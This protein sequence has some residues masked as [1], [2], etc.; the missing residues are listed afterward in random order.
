MFFLVPLREES[1]PIG[2]AQKPQASPLINT[3]LQGSKKVSDLRIFFV[4]PQPA[5]SDPEPA[6]GES[7]GCPLWL[8]FFLVP[9]RAISAITRD[10]GDSCLAITR[11]P[12]FRSVSS[13][14]RFCL[15]RSPD[16]PITGSPDLCSPL[17]ASFSQRPHPPRRFV[18]NK[19]QTPIRPSGRPNGR[20]PFSPFFRASI[21]LNFSLVFSFLLSGRQRVATAGSRAAQLRRA[22]NCHRERAANRE[23]NDLNP[24]E[25]R[26]S[27]AICHLLIASCWFSKIFQLP[28]LGAV[29]L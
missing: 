10:S 28:P 25:A 29:I 7:N 4:F 18:E 2:L 20:C 13:V 15:S 23:S 27:T 22:S 26:T 3:D 14:V 6:K 8:K 16:V 19:S 21:R 12:D 5:L 11:S 1:C 24:G 9:S 17:P